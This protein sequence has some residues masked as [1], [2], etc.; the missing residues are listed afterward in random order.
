MNMNMISAMTMTNSTVSH[1]SSNMEL[2]RLIAIVLIMIGHIVMMF[3]QP[4]VEYSRLFP[5]NS[6]TRFFWDGLSVVAVDVFILI[7]GWFGIHFKMKRM[8]EFI[9]QALFFSFIVFIV[10]VLID[11]EKFLT[12]YNVGIIF[13]LHPWDYWFVKAYLGLYIFAPILNEFIENV[14]EK[15]LRTVLILFYLFQT[16]YG[17]MS[18]QGAIWFEGGFSAVSFMGLYLLARYIKLYGQKFTSHKPFFFILCYIG[19]SLILALLAFIVTFLSFP[20]SGR[21]F[22]YTNPFVILSAL[23]LV[24]GFS[25]LKF[26]SII[27]NKLA[28]FCFAIY[29]LH[30]HEMVLRIIYGAY[31]QKWYLSENFF[32]F[33]LYVFLMILAFFFG[34]IFIDII[35][36]KVWR[37]FS[38]RLSLTEQL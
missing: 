34:A 5:I 1:R 11:K 14:S 24:I 18:I 19:I 29:L 16:I 20:I 13:M 38:N 2:L 27:I 37:I 25:K 33:L 23:S 36:I 9:F 28:V 26:Q 31:A 21:L 3:Q 32:M 7:S 22:T 8:L 10:L 12:I 4:S 15:Q 17:W 6:F 30:A 35:R